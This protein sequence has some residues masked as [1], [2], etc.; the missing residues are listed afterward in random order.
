MVWHFC[1][2]SNIWRFQTPPTPNRSPSL[3][4]DVLSA[5]SGMQ[6][7]SKR[8]LITDAESCVTTPLLCLHQS[9]RG[10]RSPA[11]MGLIV[12]SWQLYVYSC[13][14]LSLLLNLASPRWTHPKTSRGYWNW[15]DSPLSLSTC[16]CL[17][18]A[19]CRFQKQPAHWRAHARLHLDRRLQTLQLPSLSCLAMSSS[20]FSIFGV[21]EEKRE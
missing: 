19:D 2:H 6:K 17:L 21:W 5:R 12:Q 15:R 7:G 9:P 3:F 20:L 13:L 11:L 10:T 8:Q 1:F 14:S 4:Q 16:A 18:G